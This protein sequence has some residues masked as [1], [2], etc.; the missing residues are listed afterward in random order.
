MINWIKHNPKNPPKQG[1][2]LVS[3]GKNWTTGYYFAKS[4][5]IPDIWG[6][7]GIDVEPEAVTHYAV[8]N[9]PGE[10]TT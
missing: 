8:I 7:L 1:K 5:F 2:Y 9:L 10:E 6:V 4:D 3:D